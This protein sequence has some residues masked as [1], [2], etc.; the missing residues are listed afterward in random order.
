MNDTDERE[1][2]TEWAGRLMA[3]DPTLS[4]EEADK[5]A[6]ALI[7]REQ[8]PFKLVRA[9]SLELSTPKWL[10]RGLLEKA[11]FAVLFAAYGATKSFLILDWCFSIAT[12]IDSLGRKVSQGPVIYVAGEGHGGL[13]RRAK[14]WEVLRGVSLADAPVFF[15]SC[16]ANLCDDEFYSYVATEIAAVAE[17]AGPPVLIVFDTWSRNIGGDE[18]SS[19]DSAHA[20]R[21]IDSLRAPY[22]AAAVVVHHCGWDASRTRGST[23]LMAAADAAYKV[24]RDAEG[25]SVLSVEKMKDGKNPAPIAYALHDV[26]LG[27]LDDEGIELTSAATEFLPEYEIKTGKGKKTGDIT[28]DAA[29]IVSTLGNY[30][31]GASSLVLSGVLAKSPDAIRKALR[32][33]E[34]KGQVEQVSRGRYK[35][36]GQPDIVR[37]TDVSGLWD[38]RQ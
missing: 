11:V 14:A 2:L 28:P 24:E 22:N 34:E 18:N 5:K 7:R 31:D 12:G 6:A 33:L 1:H 16:A 10:I 3:D 20:V 37:T 25:V 17:L 4:A 30:P 38:K 32:R 26:G 13:M 19:L 29:R 9:G 15:S 21:V 35:V 8:S 36:S 23:V 27:L